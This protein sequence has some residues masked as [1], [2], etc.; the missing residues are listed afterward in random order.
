MLWGMV[1]CVVAC[2]VGMCVVLLVCGGCAEVQCGETH[3]GVR[4]GGPG[5]GGMKWG[6]TGW[7][8]RWVWDGLE[9]DGARMSYSGWGDME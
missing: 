1:Q 6:G 5:W 2:G 9:C 4:W 7:G 3:Y 8:S